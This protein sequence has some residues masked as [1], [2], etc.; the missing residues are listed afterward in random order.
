[1]TSAAGPQILHISG[2]FPDS[3][4]AAK[5]RVI[6]TLLAL[7]K[8]RFQHHVIS[9]NRSW[10][11]STFLFDVARNPLRPRLR[12]A[13]RDNEAGVIA[14]SYRAPPK[15]IYHRTMLEQLA[16][17]ILERIARDKIRPALIVGHKLTIEG[18]VAARVAA[19]LGVPYALTV[20]GDTDTGI[21]AVRPDLSKRLRSILDGANIVFCFAPWT[22]T[23]IERRFGALG[24]RAVLLP[25]PTTQDIILPPREAGPRI[26][27]L[28][29]LNQWRRKNARVLIEAAAIV[30]KDGL[31][32]SVSIHGDGGEAAINAIQRKIASSGAG[33]VALEGPV[34][35]ATVQA[36]LNG[37]GGF[38]LPSLRESFGLVFVEALLAGCPVLYPRGMAIDGHF[39]G[40]DF[41]IPVDAHDAQSV[42]A[43]L[44]R[45]VHDERV[46]KAKLAQW[47]SSEAA[48]R[49]QRAAIAQVFGNGLV[50]AMAS[51]SASA[52]SA[53]ANE[54]SI[55]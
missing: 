53:P 42:A 6:Q 50:Q 18:F 31:E 54:R 8:D 36:L 35:H 49:F 10:A 32:M 33:N 22:V 45:L 12:T 25:C 38:A 2:D 21:A 34:D 20:Q 39:D 41:A 13:M 51:R 7:T 30:E 5:T 16:E 23:E 52:P 19:A 4:K 3:I 47:Q 43:G 24:K 28:F 9:I 40:L 48:R 55:T 15:G 27:S 44:K 1:M 26:V 37:A 17:P 14:L 46:L 11:G 29:H